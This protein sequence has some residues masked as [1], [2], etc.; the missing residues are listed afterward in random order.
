MK[1]YFFE[2]DKFFGGNGDE[3]VVID[4]SKK[5]EKEFGIPMGLIFMSEETEVGKTGQKFGHTINGTIRFKNKN[6][7][8][9]AEEL[10]NELEDLIGRQQE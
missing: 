7:L 9:R 4:I 2:Y 10:L 5:E 3:A 8:I 1:R 6:D